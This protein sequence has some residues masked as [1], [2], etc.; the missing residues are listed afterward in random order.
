MTGIFKKLYQDPL[1]KFSIWGLAILLVCAFTSPFWMSP[2]PYVVHYDG[3]YHLPMFQTTNPKDIGLD[4][5]FVD[6]ANP[7]VRKHIE[8]SGWLIAPPFRFDTQ[9]ID[10]SDSSALPAP[11]SWQHPLGTLEDGRDT[12]AVLLAGVRVS[13][14]FGL[15]LTVVSC[16]IGLVVGLVQGYYGGW[17]DLVG[18]R[19]LEVWSSIPVLY[20]MIIFASIAAQ[21]IVAL[22]FILVLFQWQGLVG[23]VRAETFRTRT[24]DYVLAAVMM[25]VSHATIIRRHVL[26]NSTVAALSMMPFNLAMSITVL[27]SLNFLGVGLPPYQATLGAI[28]A[29]AYRNLGAT[30]LVVTSL[31]TMGGLL[32]MFVLVGTALRRV[33]DPRYAG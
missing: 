26:P 16:L 25:G 21:S 7:K 5:P 6:Y 17:V 15:L 29:Q 28:L 33:L 3:T 9:T 8:K 22:F 27:S 23:V 13:V 4:D 30:S 31:V 2:T 12:M 24:Q 1:A 18:Q 32:T 10:W 14:V 19:V 20:I 11:P